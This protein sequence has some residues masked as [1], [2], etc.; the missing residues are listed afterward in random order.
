MRKY[1]IYLVIY[2][3]GGFIL[4]RIINLVALGY[5]WDNSV[6]FGPWQPLYGAGV[7][8]AIIVYD[9]WL[10][11][12]NNIFVRYG[13]LLIV[14]I[15]TTGISEAVTGYGYEFF[16]GI[17]LWDYNLFFTCSVPYVCAIPTSLFGLLSFLVIIFIHPFIKGFIEKL[18]YKVF[19]WTFIVLFV[20]F[21]VDSTFT[22]F[23]RLLG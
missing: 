7:L 19:K 16:K 12:I 15:I 6:L 9:L 11:K 23:L 4:E 22:F 18:D 13:S 21:V 10:H 2:S 5:W 1:F 17:H 3:I 8:M 14:S 20:L